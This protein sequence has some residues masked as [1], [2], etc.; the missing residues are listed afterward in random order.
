MAIYNWSPELGQRCGGGTRDIHPGQ[1][2]TG[3]LA[4]P[5]DAGPV[6]RANLMWFKT[7]NKYEML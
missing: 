2:C 6:Q 7:S 5:E 1:F 3:D 4:L